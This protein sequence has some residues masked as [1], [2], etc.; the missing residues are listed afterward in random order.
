MPESPDR[1]PT[2]R[3]TTS[4]RPE[5][6]AGLD[7]AFAWLQRNIDDLA[8]A[9]RRS[10]PPANRPGTSA[11][12]PIPAATT[13]IPAPE[14]PPRTQPAPAAEPISPEPVPPPTETPG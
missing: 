8:R 4:R 14:P 3:S 10:R 2:S 1:P 11:A 9:D 6:P 12:T 5:P 7:L 13:P